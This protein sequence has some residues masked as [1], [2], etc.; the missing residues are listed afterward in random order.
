[1]DAVVSRVRCI[2]FLGSGS[3]SYKYGVRYAITTKNTKMKGQ[4]RE[5]FLSWRMG[6]SAVSSSHVGSSS[7]FLLVRDILSNNLI[8][9]S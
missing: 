2:N 3:F 9:L 8:F 1:M 6:I 4:I 5:M 7:P